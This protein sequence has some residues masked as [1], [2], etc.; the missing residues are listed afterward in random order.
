MNIAD[1]FVHN[2]NDLL[3]YIVK[4]SPDITFWTLGSENAKQG[5]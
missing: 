1:H 3:T 5:Y 2:V 4:K